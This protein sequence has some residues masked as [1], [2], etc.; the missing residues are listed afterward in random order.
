MGRFQTGVRSSM[1]KSS[2]LHSLARFVTTI[3]IFLVYC[4]R[5]WCW[6]PSGHV[7]EEIDR[8]EKALTLTMY[9]SSTQREHPQLCYT[10][11]IPLTNRDLPS[12]I[13]YGKSPEI[14]STVMPAAGISSSSS[15][16]GSIYRPLRRESTSQ[17]VSLAVCCTPSVT[18]LP[19]SVT[20]HAVIGCSCRF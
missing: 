7:V 3:S 14:P 20:L 5:P 8:G 6:T 9:A 11:F 16:L 13:L 2:L 12:A 17:G 19:H 10:M 1:T 15:V 4:L 18:M